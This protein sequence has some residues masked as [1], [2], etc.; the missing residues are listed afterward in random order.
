MIYQERGKGQQDVTEA[1]LKGGGANKINYLHIVP[2]FI[3]GKK[4]NLKIFE[5]QSQNL[6]NRHSI[7]PLMT[8]WD[9]PWGIGSG[10]WKVLNITKAI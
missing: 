7:G 2:L 3:S 1:N 4:K 9:I 10:N 6:R 5:F 8:S